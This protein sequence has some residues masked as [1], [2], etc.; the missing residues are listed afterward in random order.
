MMF[1]RRRLGTAVVVANSFLALGAGVAGANAAIPTGPAPLES[2]P[3]DRTFVPPKV[4]PITV[5]IGP[6]IIDGKVMDP[7]LQVTTP[8]VT[9]K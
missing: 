5:A 2:A 6:T 7:G 9:V 8:G 4:G 3:V 1:S